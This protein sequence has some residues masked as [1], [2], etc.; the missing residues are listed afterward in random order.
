[1]PLFI[2]C[3]E[4]LHAQ[5]AHSRDH[6]RAR[7]AVRAADH[8]GG[9]LRDGARRLTGPVAFWAAITLALAIGVL[10]AV[11]RLVADQRERVTD[12][13][14]LVRAAERLDE[15]GFHRS[16]AVLYRWVLR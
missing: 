1:M 6:R 14:S 13:L 2:N 4:D 12:P 11:F 15:H 3:Q 7:R 16:A 5:A 8:R 10:E 9:Q